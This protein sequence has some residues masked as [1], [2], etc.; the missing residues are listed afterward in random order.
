MSIDR[1]TRPI[2]TNV[3]ALAT[4]FDIPV[5]CVYNCRS[6]LEVHRYFSVHVELNFMPA[7]L[8]KMPGN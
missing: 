4:T 2:M 1:M 6:P 3:S 8:D 5:S 7:F